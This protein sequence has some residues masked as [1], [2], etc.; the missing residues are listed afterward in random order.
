MLYIT[1]DTHGDFSRFSTDN[2]P[3]QK[4]LSPRD[5][6]VICGDFGGVWDGSPQ[7]KYW[8][9]WLEK[10]RF[11]VLFVSGNHENY[12]LLKSYPI[13]KWKG[14]KVQF[15]WSSVIHLMRGQ[16]YEI[17][18]KRIYTM[19]GASSHDISGGI[20]E[21]DDPDFRIKKA[22][23]EARQ[24]HYRV[25]HHSWW[26]EELPS[27]EE[28]QE[29]EKNLDASGRKVDIIIS[30]CCPSSVTDLLSDGTHQHDQLTDYFDLLK[31]N[32]DFDLWFFGH[33]HKDMVIDDKYILL[34]KSML[35]VG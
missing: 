28:Y 1:G 30:H 26:K 35:Q 8:L 5:Y 33:Y 13:R 20:L 29:S 12:D 7:D 9:D 17:A 10:K 4:R 22:R 11:T 6:V 31:S 27:D 34:Y 24:A 14:G 21:A 19:G 23:L 2:F 3:F 32:C 18:E 15:I 25:N 16:V